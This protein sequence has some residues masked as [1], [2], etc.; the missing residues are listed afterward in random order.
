MRSEWVCSDI[1]KH[2]FAALTYE[3]RLACEVSLRTG[4]R[5]GDVLALKSDKLF[6]YNGRFTIKEQKTGKPRRVYIPLDLLD[7]L[8][9]VAGR[10]YVFENRVDP[11][12]QRTR[13]AVFK[14]LKRASRAFRVHEN[15]APHSLRKAYAVEWYAKTGDI[16]KVQGLLNHSDEAV[17]MLY[18]LADCIDKKRKRC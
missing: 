5:I 8:R 12:R 9:K 6:Q 10:Y 7:K 11:R 14:D 4:L 13:Q 15:V 16:K 2:I 18:A 17:T 3:N 1:M